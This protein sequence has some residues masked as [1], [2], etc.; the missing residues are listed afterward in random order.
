MLTRPS[1][2]GK[3]RA[4]SLTTS[5]TSIWVIS[6]VRVVSVLARAAINRSST[7]RVRWLARSSI[8]SS[9][10]ARFSSLIRSH[11]RRSRSAYPRIGVIGV[12]SSWETVAMKSAFIRSARRSRVMSRIVITL[13]AADPG[14]STR[15]TCRDSDWPSARSY[16]NSVPWG[17]LGTVTTLSTISGSASPVGAETPVIRAAAGLHN[18]SAPS[19][20]TTAMPS[21]AWSTTACSFAVSAVKAVNVWPARTELPTAVVSATSAGLSLSSSVHDLAHGRL[22]VTQTGSC[23]LPSASTPPPDWSS[24]RTATPAVHPGGRSSPPRVRASRG[25]KDGG[26]Q[27]S[28]EPKRSPECRTTAYSSAP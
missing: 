16:S 7:S 13:A 25:I 5:T 21:V 4:A 15:V 3:A 14:T 10:W 26:S 28:C 22:R 24:R 12:R 17:P 27:S 2:S 20:S 8:V 1:S 18:R 9:T 6:T 23:L 11:R 19:A